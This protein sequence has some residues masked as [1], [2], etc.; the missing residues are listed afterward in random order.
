MIPTETPETCGVDRD[1]ADTVTTERQ[2]ARGGRLQRQL[3]ISRLVYNTLPVL[4]CRISAESAAE[5]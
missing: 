3:S 2:D 1:C 4:R 5:S